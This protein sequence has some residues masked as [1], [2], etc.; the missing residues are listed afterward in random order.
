MTSCADSKTL[1]L[2][3]GSFIPE[4]T[5]YNHELTQ[6]P[7]NAIPLIEAK[8]GVRSRHYADDKECT[9]DLA[10]H[11]A[12]NCLNKIHFDAK[13]IDAII[14][15]TSSPDR[16]QPATATIVQHSI[17]ASNAFA[18]DINSVCSGAVYGIAMA[19][20]LIK[21]EMCKTVLVVAAEVYSRI[22][23]PADFST[24]P[25]FGDGAGAVLLTR[26]TE[27]GRGII[28][29]IL[30]TDG[31]GSDVIEIPGG[32]TKLPFNKMN[33]PKDAFFKMDGKKVYSFAIEK[34]TEVINDIL[35]A[36]GVDA[37][38]LRYIIPHQANINIIRQ[39]S[40]NVRID[41]E[42][43]IVNLDRLGNTAA[44]S[45]LIGLD[46]VMTTGNVKPHDLI[47]LVGFGGGLSWGA[48]LI[49]L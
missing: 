49:S 1:L 36:T 21:S 5:V 9:S 27:A 4:R 46:E 15:A 10:I 14:L 26:S 11:A 18:Y 32:G 28:K 25:Y 40:Q 34:G 33:E 29:S 44:A 47:A 35:Q 38:S 42:K 8:T 19:D 30:R 13:N 2:S 24:T 43:F 23:N 7:K 17:H 45:I 31:S 22:L 3:T 37:K 16:I 20:A 48:N 6:F 12:Q 41:L 39:L